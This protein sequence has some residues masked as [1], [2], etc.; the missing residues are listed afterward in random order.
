MARFG[1]EGISERIR[2]AWGKP[3]PT[4]GLVEMLAD[5]HENKVH[6]HLFWI[7]GAPFEQDSDMAELLKVWDRLMRTLRWGI[8]RMKFTTFNTIPP[9]PLCRFLPGAS[10]EDRYTWFLKDWRPKNAASRHIVV[11]PF[12]KNE[13]RA[14]DVAQMLDVPATVAEELC[15]APET[16]DLAP[17]IGDFRRMQA[18]IIRWPQ[19]SE[20]RFRAGDVFRSRMGG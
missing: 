6:T 1:V 5:L 14:L 8:C 9:A 18:E 20:G 2:L 13:S 16:V 3:V 12:R 19:S 7:A 10:Y 17:K 11:I 4:D 15:K